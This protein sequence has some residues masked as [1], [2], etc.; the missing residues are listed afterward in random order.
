[1]GRGSSADGPGQALE[2]RGTDVDV[3]GR[4][5]LVNGKRVLGYIVE[6]E[7]GEHGIYSRRNEELSAEKIRAALDQD[8]G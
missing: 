6:E 2:T 3:D 7:N 1:M 5:L 8:Q 4:P